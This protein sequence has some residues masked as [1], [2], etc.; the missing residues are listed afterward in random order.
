MEDAGACTAGATV[1]L[2]VSML[3]AQRGHAAAN[4]VAPLQQFATPVGVLLMTAGLYA[5]LHVTW[6]N[7]RGGGNMCSSRGRHGAW[8]VGSG[9][10]GGGGGTPS[11]PTAQVEGRQS[12]KRPHNEPWA[13]SECAHKR[14]KTVEATATHRISKR[15]REE[16]PEQSQRRAD[17]PVRPY[18]RR[19]GC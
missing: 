16:K 5:F 9:G 13:A 19:R 17:Q 14:R 18:Q 6:R 10:G 12:R 2:G 7:C 8:S 3:H 15:R 1:R 11:T 4:L